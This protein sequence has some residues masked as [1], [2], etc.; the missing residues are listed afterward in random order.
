MTPHYEQGRV[1]VC[2]YI[3]GEEYQ[4]CVDF[5]ETALGG[6]KEAGTWNDG[7]IGRYNALRVGKL[8][9]VAL[10]KVL[11]ANVDWDVKRFDPG[12]DFVAN[13][14]RFEVKTRSEDW[15]DQVLVRTDHVGKADIYVAA[16]LLHETDDSATV[17]LVGYLRTRDLKERGEVKDGYRGS[18][19]N[20]VVNF[21]DMEP[22]ARL[23]KFFQGEDL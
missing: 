5:S 8:G 22:M 17:T 4:H 12:F 23:Y 15:H 14:E 19:K 6:K 18:W 16:K 3:N 7:L 1:C 2:V 9:E 11:D 21:A 10:S 20:Y 13:G